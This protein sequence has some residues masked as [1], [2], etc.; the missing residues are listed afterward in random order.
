MQ[1]TYQ[2]VKA[3]FAWPKIKQS[4]FDFV[5]ACQVC[6]QAKVEHV[7]SPGLLQP[8]PVPSQAWTMVSL[9]FIEGLPKSGGFDVILV[10]IDKFS[11]YAHFIPMSHP[12]TALSVAQLYFNNIYKLHGLP[13]ALISDRDKVFTST[14]WKELFALSDTQLLMSS[15]YHPQ[16]DG[17]T[18]RLNQCL[19]A[20]LRCSVHACPKQ[21]S[22]WLSMAEYWY[23]TTY[24]S[25]LGYTPFEVLYG[26]PPKHFGLSD[27]PQVT[28]PDLANWLK[29][30]NL[31]NK[32]IQ[33]QLLRAQQRMKHQADKGRSERSFEIGDMVYLKLQPHI[34]SSVAPRSNHKLSFKF[35]GPFQVLQKVGSVAYKLELP[36][37]A[38]IHRVVHVSQLKKH[39]PPQ[40]QV[41][42][43]LDSIVHGPVVA[44][45]P[46]QVLEQLFVPR[47]GSTAKRI[48][49]LWDGPGPKYIS[50]EDEQDLRRRYPEAPAWGQAG[51]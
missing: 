34:Q 1:A 19:E 38:Q 16:T 3:L 26:H 41:S 35:F 23:N 25:A 43:E 51:G 33:Q 30:R 21:W 40:T 9:D 47:A 15:A 18:E 2:R 8:L 13:E 28:V 31:L 14:L 50:C 27:A 12:Y 6:Q 22:K 11:K 42:S 24:Q 20:F 45:A 37:Q 32:V 46:I 7:R 44:L 29:D 4:V 5:Q 48:R 10:V 39:V 49:V 17:Q 36:P